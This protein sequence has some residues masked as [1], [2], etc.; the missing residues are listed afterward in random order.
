MS[1]GSEVDVAKQAQ[2]TSLMTSLTSKFRQEFSSLQDAVLAVPLGFQVHLPARRADADK[3]HAAVAK[4]SACF[5]VPDNAA[6]TI[7][8]DDYTRF[9][10]G[11]NNSQ[12]DRVSNQHHPVSLQHSID[13]VASSTDGQLQQRSVHRQ[14]AQMIVMTSMSDKCLHAS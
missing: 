2:F 6:D 7:T 5:H 1:C 11:T 12:A 4:L 13:S 8:I 9:V 14:A 10:H 3:W